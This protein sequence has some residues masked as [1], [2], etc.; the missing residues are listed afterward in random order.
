MD[1]AVGVKGGVGFPFFSGSDYQDFLDFG[2]ST[3]EG[4]GSY[5]RTRFLLSYSLG[6]SAEI[7]FFNFL[8]LQ[9]EAH[10][11]WSGGAYGYPENYYLYSYKEYIRTTCVELPLLLKIRIN[12]NAGNSYWRRFTLFA[13]PGIAFKLSD[14]KVKSEVDGEDFTSEKLAPDFLTDRYYF[15]L[16]GFGFDRSRQSQKRFTTLEFRY[17]MGLDS[18]IHPESGIT[19]FKQNNIQFILVFAFGTDPSR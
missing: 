16:F 13:G 19:D 1:F 15:L 5:Y 10:I 11:S 3:V 18:I 14:G 4:Y 9:P 2:T 8:S 12:R 7:G 17:H 6:V